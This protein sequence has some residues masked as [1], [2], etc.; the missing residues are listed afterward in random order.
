MAKS[1]DEVWEEWRTRVNMSSAELE[2]WLESGESRS[3]GDSEEGEST[4]HR[5]GRRIVE[6]QR[7][8]RDDLTDGQWDWMR[9]VVGYINRHCAQV[10]EGDVATSRWRY[11]L[12]NWGHDPLK[13]DGCAA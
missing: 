10:P 1:R 9:K 3:V 2:D 11:S 7:T 4:G 6:I 5:S 13:E 8:A 12:M